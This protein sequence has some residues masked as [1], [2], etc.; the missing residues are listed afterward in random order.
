M[1]V[2]YFIYFAGH[3]WLILI[4]IGNNSFKKDEDHMNNDD[5]IAITFE[6]KEN[7]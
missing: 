5:K 2:I 1:F 3:Y 4:E 7:L 6:V